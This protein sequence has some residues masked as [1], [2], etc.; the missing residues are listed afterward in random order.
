MADPQE[1]LTPYEGWTNGELKTAAAPLDLGLRGDR[2][3]RD[4]PSGTL[5]PAVV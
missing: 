4:G 2:N 5:P 3:V 1:G